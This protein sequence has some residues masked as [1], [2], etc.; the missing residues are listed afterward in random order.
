[1]G[2]TLIRFSNVDKRFGS[3]VIYSGL[4]LDIRRT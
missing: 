1:M 2:E 4:S 3:K